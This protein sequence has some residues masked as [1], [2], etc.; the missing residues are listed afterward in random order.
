MHR[1]VRCINDPPPMGTMDDGSRAI[2]A[3]LPVVL[4]LA[5]GAA[6]REQWEDDRVVLHSGSLC[7]SAP[8]PKKDVLHGGDRLKSRGKEADSR[9]K[10]LC[11]EGV[12]G[13]ARRAH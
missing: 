8:K 11:V 10:W 6:K 9:E 4:W 3:S 7:V 2:K 12:G 13:Q 1:K 5:L